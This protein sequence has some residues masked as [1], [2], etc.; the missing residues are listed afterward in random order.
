ME[1]LCK[2]RIQLVVHASEVMT[3]WTMIIVA[4]VMRSHQD[5]FRRLSWQH[6]PMDWVLVG[7]KKGKREIS[8]MS[9]F[10]G[11]R[12]L[13][14]WWFLFPKL[15][16]TKKRVRERERECMHLLVHLEW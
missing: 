6:Y 3:A 11:T 5:I 16:K 10:F 7:V 2:Q 4:Q 15:G 1:Q 12:Q 13:G 8:K 9:W 14:D